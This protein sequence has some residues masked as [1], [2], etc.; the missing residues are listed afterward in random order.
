MTLKVTLNSHWLKPYLTTIYVSNFF[1]VNST[2]RG[3]GN[4]NPDR[5]IPAGIL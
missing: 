1:L 3:Y 2:G 5:K 4:K